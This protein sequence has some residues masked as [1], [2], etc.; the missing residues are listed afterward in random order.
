MSKALGLQNSFRGKF[1]KSIFKG[2]ASTF[3]WNLEKKQKLTK[4]AKKQTNKTNKQATQQVCSCYLFFVVCS[5]FFVVCSLFFVVCSLFFDVCSLFLDVCSL[6][7]DVCSL[8]LDVC[9]RF[10]VQ[11]TSNIKEEEK[12]SGKN[13]T[14]GLWTGRV[15]SGPSPKPS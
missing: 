12:I 15:C 1:F 9:S 8:F 3:G 13:I 4:V 14:W 10:I 2:R 5:L 11:R 6:F 7:F